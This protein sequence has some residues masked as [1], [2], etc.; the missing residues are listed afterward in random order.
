MDGRS[1]PAQCRR[2]LLQQR[3]GTAEPGHR[4]EPRGAARAPARR[5]RRRLVHVRAGAGVGRHVGRAAPAGAR[6]GHPGAQLRRR[7]VRGRPGLSAIP[8][9]RASVAS[10]RRGLRRDRSR[11]RA[12]DGR[13]RVPHV[14][15]LP[16]PLLEAEVHAHGARARGGEPAGPRSHG[17]LRAR[18]GEG[19]PLHRARPPLRPGRL[20]VAPLSRL[21]RRA[22][23][24]VAVP[25]L[26][27]RPP[28]RFRPG[29]RG[30]QPTAPPGLRG[31]GGARGLDT[32]P[33]LL[34]GAVA[35]EGRDAAARRRPRR[36][37]APGGG[38]SVR[39]RH[40]LSPRGAAR[41]AVRTASLLAAG[42]RRRRGLP[43]RTA[44]PAASG[45]ERPTP[46]P[47][48]GVRPRR[49]ESPA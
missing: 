29:D 45:R 37:A 28:P 13:V 38:S 22:L 6:I 33:R 46:R 41:G 12:H 4:R 31:A 18:V 19:S 1:Q 47:A 25:A 15:L 2:P 39:G 23:P 34:P 27:C 11:P 24:P 9:R 16:A 14:P 26:D 20:G 17:G 49:R 43:E 8:A 21:L 44:P 30:R 32:S 35:S 42:K 3:G 10:G 48:R 40:R 36:A 5:P 7:R